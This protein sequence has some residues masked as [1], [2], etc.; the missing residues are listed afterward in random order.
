MASSKDS[1]RTVREQFAGRKF[2][3]KKTGV[4]LTIPSDVIPRQFFAFGD[5]FIDVGDGWY[6]RS[7]GSYEEI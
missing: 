1:C 2:R 4:V 6:S 5:C 3:C 7:S